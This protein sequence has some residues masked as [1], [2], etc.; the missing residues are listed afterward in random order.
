V[1][2]KPVIVLR[3]RT[4]RMEGVKEGWLTLS[5]TRR[6]DILRECERQ[7]DHPFRPARRASRV[8]GDGRAADRIV[9]VLERS[10]GGT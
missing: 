2:G 7:L 10:L 9:R 6:D 3:D 1:L 4:E 5:G 8:F